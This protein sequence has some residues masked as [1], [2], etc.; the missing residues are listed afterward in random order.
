MMTVVEREYA[1]ARVEHLG[2]VFVELADTLVKDFDVVDFLHN[3]TVRSVELLEV[4]AAGLM[5]ADQRGA[6][7]IMASSDER[8]ETME[9]FEI[10]HEQ[11]PCLDSF[12]TGKAIVNVDL[13]C[14]QGSWPQFA[15]AACA[16]GFSYSH[17]LPLRLRDEVIGAL[18]LFCTSPVPLT[19]ADI[20]LAQALADIATIGLLQERSVREQSVL[21][22]QLQSALNSRVLIEQAKGVLA[23]K[24]GL[25]VAETFTMMRSYAR[26]N[27]LGLST[28][29]SAVINGT[30]DVQA[31]LH[32]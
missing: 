14:R 1:M 6:L 31:I 22:G 7:R 5:L 9:L 15:A 24:T 21:A 23:G 12:T 16:A 20:T 13:N 10:Q 4:D 25:D 8:A 2:E 27:G 18:N 26:T 29:A 30:S 32:R 17:A 3:V 11:G 28:V 19:E